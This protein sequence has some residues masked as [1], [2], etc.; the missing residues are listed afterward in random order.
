MTT[1]KMRRRR[2][3]RRGGR[4]VL[5]CAIALL[6][7]INVNSARGVPG[8]T[9]GIVGAPGNGVAGGVTQF[10]PS[11]QAP[12]ASFFAYDPAFTGGV[13]V[14]AGDVTGD[15][16][17][18]IITGA[19]AGGGPRVKVYDG[20]TGAERQFFDPFGTAFTGGVY[21]ATANNSGV[22]E[23]I[24]GTGA[25]G[26]PHV[27][28]FDAS[29]PGVGHRLSIEPYDNNF[30][31]GVRVAAADVTGDGVDDIITGP[32][33]GS[34]AAGPHVKVFNGATGAEISSFFAF[35]P[36]FT[37]GVYVA[38]GDINNDNVPD[39][40]TGAG[41][42]GGP[43]VRAFSGVDNSPL[44]QFQPYPGF[45]GGVRVAVGDINNDG[46]ADIVTAPG[47][48]GGPHVR[49]FSGVDGTILQ[50]FYAHPGEVRT[51]IH[52]AATPL[53]LGPQ[54]DHFEN[55]LPVGEW[56]NPSVWNG[57]AGPG[58]PGPGDIVTIQ[59]GG[60]ANPNLI[61]L[62]PPVVGGPGPQAFGVQVTGHTVFDGGVL[63]TNGLSL[64][65]PL[66]PQPLNP[67]PSSLGIGGTPG[68]PT[69]VVVQDLL[70]IRDGLLHVNVDGHLNARQINLGSPDD[71]GAPQ[72]GVFDGAQVD[73]VRLNAISGQLQVVGPGSNL[74][75]QNGARIGGD[76]TLG[77]NPFVFIGP[78]GRMEILGPTSLFGGQLFIDPL[79][80]FVSPGPFLLGGDFGLV[81]PPL[82][83]PGGFGGPGG[84]P[85]F[86][87]ATISVKG[88][89]QVQSLT[90]ENDPRAPLRRLTIKGDGGAVIVD[91][92]VENRGGKV[93]PGDSVGTLY[94][95]KNGGMGGNY[96]QEMNGLLEIEVGQAG[97]DL[98]M[99]EGSASLGGSLMVLLLPPVDLVP[100]TEHDFLLAG[101]GI[102]G[103]FD[104]MRVPLNRF[105][106][107]IFDVTVD[108]NRAYLTVRD[109]SFLLP[110]PEPTSAVLLVVAGAAVAGRRRRRER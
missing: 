52:V 75:A 74:T 4:F 6:L 22:S 81:P 102:T 46:I 77:T 1:D 45:Q 3:V 38:A 108:N 34:P 14:A 28:V 71:S 44:I 39:I 53:P 35:D 97:I 109:V 47:P 106:E 15:G 30:L 27:R 24:T 110:V 57:P 107:P 91:S 61:G 10:N 90:L 78:G 5:G 36:G 72:L 18:D 100:G 7:T 105:G 82:P 88:D 96:I 69:Q 20:A 101:D 103:M 93:A 29:N 51:G 65:A 99:V 26:G 83:P 31:G 80:Q 84:Q 32:G 66:P 62:N 79:G 42:G 59:G 8:Y 33:P 21:V 86:N 11:G 70:N 19:G 50:S 60:F 64:V 49:A 104:D 17:A 73:V 55:V 43:H 85:G 76:P 89:L 13:R 25:G 56:N 68:Q 63:N 40:I 2:W 58:V 41:P 67:I 16:V 48:G 94:I 9:G 12:A 54:R 37:G 92:A 23:I 87:P 98:L 95:S